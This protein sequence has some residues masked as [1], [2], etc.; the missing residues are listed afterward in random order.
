MY[1]GALSVTAVNP[2]NDIWPGSV[3]AYYGL[4]V[5]TS[6]WGAS[7]AGLNGYGVY[8]YATSFAAPQAAG[9]AILLRS[10]RPTLNARQIAELLRITGDSVDHVNPTLRYR[11]GRRINLHR[12]VATRDTPACRIKVWE[13]QDGNDSLFFVGETLAIRATYINYL[14]PVQ[15]LSIKLVSLSPYIEVID[16]VYQAG[17]LSTLGMHVQAQPF[18][19]RVANGTPVGSTVPIL[20]VYS[21]DG[22]YLDY[23]VQELMGLNPPYVHLPSAQLRTTIGGNGRFGYYDTPQNRIGVGAVWRTASASWLFEGGLVL[24]DTTA[25]LCTRGPG[26]G[27]YR[28]FLPTSPAQ[29]TYTNLYEVGA[30]ESGSDAAM[31]PAPLPFA[32]RLKTYGLLHEPANPFIAFVYEV[33]NFSGQAYTDLALGWWMDWDVGNNPLT[34]VASVDQTYRMVYAQNGTSRYAGALLLSSQT[35]VLHV[36]RVDTFIGTRQ[37]YQRIFQG[38]GTPSLNAAGD[39]FTAISAKGISLPAGAKDTVV[40]ALIAGDSW[41]EFL[42]HA[43]AAIAWYQCFLQQNPTGLDLGPDRSLCLGDSLSIPGFVEYYWNTGAYTSAVHP[44]QSGTYSVL[45]RDANGCWDYDEVRLTVNS[46][47][48]ANVQFNP[49]LS[50]TVGQTLSGIDL[51]PTYDRLWRIEAMPSW[52]SYTGASFSH[53]FNAA[54]SYRIRLIREETAST[55]RDS[56]EWI[57]NVGTTGHS[58][59]FPAQAI[60]VYPNPTSGWVVVSGVAHDTAQLELRDVFGRLLWSVPL[61]QSPSIYPL[62]ASLPAGTYIW[63]VGT[64]QGLLIY[65]P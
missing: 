12:A 41:A 40:L 15:N 16:S 13:A 39:V 54:G 59:V 1:D 29:R 57:A 62:P 5:S 60:Q 10:W 2:A 51:G 38:L 64:T 3:Q 35:A 8:A 52:M 48:P 30:V 45:V 53:V 49:G 36:G 19:V 37:H 42:Q 4:D 63:K 44:T 11:L 7:T 43:D 55:C 32:I 33:E 61:S 21:G 27:M 26:G 23:E 47:L 46:L 24:A 22:G 65:T 18:R 31:D 50:L 25:H 6:G 9:C 28:D 17:N 20:W 56:L 58:Q 14:S 34:D